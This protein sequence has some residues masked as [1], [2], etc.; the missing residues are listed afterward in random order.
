MCTI[1]LNRA[2]A[3]NSLTAAAKE[4]LL[5]ALAGA[6]DDDE[7]RVVVL[8]GSGKAFC[9]GHD[10]REHIRGLEQGASNLLETVSK[11][12]NPIA[13]ILATM[14][15]PVIAAINGVAAGAG[16][17][18]ALA[19]D[20]RIMVEGAGMNTAF[21][22]IALSCDSGASF[23]L[24]RLVGPMVA[25]DLLFNPRTIPAAECLALGLVSQV[26]AAEDFETTVQQVAERLAAGPTRAYGAMRQAVIS[27]STMPLADALAAE[28]AHMGTTG[29]TAD[30]REAVRAFLA[31]EAPAFTGQ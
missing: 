14:N 15:K 24:P 3:M 26:V 18:F 8:T 29:A 10:L 21:A 11:H 12:Y 6:A 28:E 23:W 17:S 27:G 13:T 1:R 2:D 19:A 7:V 30:H 5:T 25:K 16:M 9:V 4:A 20:V 31:K 22:G